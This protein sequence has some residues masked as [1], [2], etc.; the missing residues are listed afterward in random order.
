MP[1][2]SAGSVA[3]AAGVQVAESVVGV[4]G[5]AVEVLEVA[6]CPDHPHYCLLRCQVEG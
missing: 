4:A 1:A 6:V 5:F 2:E 3:V